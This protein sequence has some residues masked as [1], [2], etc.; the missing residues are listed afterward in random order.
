MKTRSRLLRRTRHGVL[1]GAA[2]LLMAS[3]MPY[4]GASAA[5]TSWLELDGNE[6]ANNT[7]ATGAVD[8]AK[9]G[10]L[11]VV[12]NT[13]SRAGVN[14]LFDGGHFNGNTT[15][16][17]APTRTST[18]TD[19]AAASFKVDPLSVD[20]TPDCGV[21]DPTAYTGAG[22]ET[23]GGLISTDT[24]GT[25]SVP[26]KDDLSNVFAVAHMNATTN[27]VFFGGERVVSNGDSHIDYEFLQSTVTIPNACSGTF[28]GNRTQG[29]FLLSVDFTQGGTFGGIHLYKW[30]CDKTFNAAHNGN[31]CNPPANGQSVPHY[32]ETGTTA[33]FLTVNAG[34]TP[35]G[36]GGWVCRNA[37]GSPTQTLA[38]NE[39]MEGG[40]NLADPAVNFTG[41]ISTFLPHTRTSQSFTSTLKDFEIIPFNTCAHPTVSTTIL[42]GAT[43]TTA[44]TVTPAS[45]TTPAAVHINVGDTLRD[46]ANL[47]GYAGTPTGTYAYTLFT[48]LPATNTTN[49]CTAT[50]SAQGSGTFSGA[51]IPESN[52][53][54]FN[55]AGTYA[56]QVAITFTDTRNLGTPKSG[57]REELVIVEPNHPAPHST[58]VVQIKDTFSVTGFSSNATGNVVV[59]LYTD[60]ACTTRAQ[61][62]GVDVPDVTKTVAQATAGSETTFVAAL[63]GTYYY[64]ISYAGD[65][66]NVAFDDCTERVGITI[67][68]LT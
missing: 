30:Q 17:T 67:T 41:C 46:S 49:P 4:S 8:W 64:K 24:F 28:S 33:A 37:D 51:A 14:G 40:I 54:T 5:P 58:P 13:Y 68:S 61:V 1:V 2:G 34:T 39:L 66:N 35:I 16:P 27:E 36:C 48:G 38:Q 43:G 7:N 20:T 59:G 19:I 18:G 23:N 15:P 6:I 22:S 3:V 56:F 11:S 9:S 55:Q 31:V 50:S 60:S 25:S 63:A 65:N 26:N 44:A 52:A 62:A 45:G 21:G 12:N 42:S 29:D 47:A 53:V 10:A 32:H 57:C